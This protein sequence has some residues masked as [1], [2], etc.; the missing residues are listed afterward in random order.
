MSVTIVDGE[1]CLR[2][3]HGDVYCMMSY[4]K[5]YDNI[6]D[7]YHNTVLEAFMDAVFELKISKGQEFFIGDLSFK[8]SNDFT[9]QKFHVNATC[10]VYRK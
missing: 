6:P 10:M 3:D 8:K 9:K 7:N 5:V 2:G 4:S 1:N